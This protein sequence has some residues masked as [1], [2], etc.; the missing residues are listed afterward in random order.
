MREDVTPTESVKH[1]LKIQVWRM[2]SYRALGKLHVIPKGQMVTAKYY[3]E[4]ILEN[5]LLPD[6]NRKKEI[7]S[8]LERKLLPNMSNAIFQQDGAPAHTSHMSQN[9]LQHNVD[10]F[11][12]K[13]VWPGNSPDLSPIENLWALVKE[14]I[15][16]I[17][18]ATNEKTLI[19]NVKDAWSHISPN[20]LESLISGMPKR[21]KNVYN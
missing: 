18:P 10:S 14:N 2:M 11:W 17:E 8:V 6:F 4:E 15:K 16:D 13:G 5:N 20:I 3:V 12:D 9:W 21:I 19:K 1:P 7:A